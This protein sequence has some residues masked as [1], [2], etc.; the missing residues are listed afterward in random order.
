MAALGFGLFI[1]WL[2]DS[3]LSEAVLSEL[4]D[5]GPSFFH[6][7]FFI[8]LLGL[9]SKTFSECLGVALTVLAIELVFEVI[10]IFP[11]SFYSG[12]FDMADIFATSFGAFTGFLVL[13]APIK[14]EVQEE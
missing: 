14:C 5:S 7:I 3:N 2:R 13:I 12:T 9:H 11:N 8:T 4:N 1:Y 10:Q 6:T